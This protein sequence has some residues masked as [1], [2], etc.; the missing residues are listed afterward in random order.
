MSPT[1][2]LKHFFKW[3]CKKI[4]KELN[5]KN[6]ELNLY[7]LNIVYIVHIVFPVERCEVMKV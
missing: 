4:L 5:K 7:G 3:N 2:M 6:T 1:Y